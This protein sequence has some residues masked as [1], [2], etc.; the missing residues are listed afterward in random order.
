[1]I[2]SQ[3]FDLGFD[4]LWADGAPMHVGFIPKSNWR[5]AHSGAP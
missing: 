1:M 5:V 2:L 4:F 3:L